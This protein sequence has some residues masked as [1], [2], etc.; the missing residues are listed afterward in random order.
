MFVSMEA[1]FAILNSL[2]VY[3]IR[4]VCFLLSLLAG[5]SICAQENLPH[6]PAEAGISDS[7]QIMELIKKAGSLQVSNPDST[8]FLAAKAF[9]KC[10]RSK[11]HE[12][13]GRALALMGVGYRNLGKLK[14]SITYFKKAIPYIKQQ[15]KS[16]D[17][18]L[19]GAYN[20]MFG[21][22]FEMGSFDSAAMNCYKVIQLYNQKGQSNIN[23][24]GAFVN[25]IIDAFQYLGIS[26]YKLGF[27]HKALHYLQ[28]AER[29]SAADSNRYQMLSIVENKANV[30]LALHQPDSALIFIDRAGKMAAEAHDSSMIKTTRLNLATVMLQKKQ[31]QESA[32]IMEQLLAEDNA[33]PMSEHSIITS[34]ILADAYVNLKKYNEAL[35]LLEPAEAQAKSIGLNHSV[36]QPY[37]LRSRIYEALGKTG[38][39][40][41]QLKIA[42][43][44]GDSIL[45][46]DK[47]QALNILD[48]ALETADKDKQLNANNIRINNQEIKIRNK[49]NLLFT[50]A[51]CTLFLIMLL[52]ALYRSYK[53]KRRLQ[54]E[55]IL[56]LNKENEI[57]QLKAMMKGEEQERARL[58]RELHDGF[59]S[60]LSA[61]KMNFSA[62][63]G[64]IEQEK[65][66]E[67]MQ[68][69]QETIQ[70]LRQTAHNLMPEVLLHGSLEEAVQMYCERMSAAHQL[71]I[72]FQVYGYLPRLRTEF[73]LTLYRMIQE[74]LQNIVKHSG[75]SQALVQINNFDDVISITVEDNGSGILDHDK[76]KKVSSGIAN[77][78][79]RVHALNGFINIS[80]K[81][82]EGTTIYFEFEVK[83]KIMATS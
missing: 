15:Q 80:G 9:D 83:D 6:Y 68:L 23:P 71:N 28:R 50:T 16:S 7:A 39:A 55:R 10:L 18:Y 44:L 72:D 19:A 5:A 14:E 65:F 69:F 57:V 54:E 74:A 24:P 33:V 60:Q 20:V 2:A 58:A 67:N 29:L 37:M 52:A 17:Y 22:Y 48:V 63:S 43:Q 35:L 11:Y 73:E 82:G 1:C 45:S 13:A 77:L 81:S 26:W 78:K 59:I 32:I 8:L 64:Y 27:F 62:L 56:S 66:T 53:H 75:A 49:N 40:L 51:A 79:E 31:Y 25:P 34:Y 3:R 30:Y 70:D 41:E 47:I 38:L 61:I 4:Y 42:H 36:I 21:S 46:N 76:E 12:G